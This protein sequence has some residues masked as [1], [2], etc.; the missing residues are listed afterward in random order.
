[1]DAT[2]SRNPAARDVVLPYSP[3][4]AFSEFH[5]RTQ[6]WAVLVC[7][8]RAGKTTAL[9][10][11]MLY[12]ALMGPGDGRYAYIAPLYS[13]AKAIAWDIL[14][15]LTEQVTVRKYES[16]LRIDL[17]N[18][19]R[20]RLFGS[21]NPDTLR[22][23]RF[24]GVAIDEVG[25][26]KPNLFDEVVRPAL[27]DRQGWAVFSGTPKGVGYFRDLYDGAKGDPTWFVSYLP[28]SATGILSPDELRDAAK[29]MSP[30]VYAQE[31]ECS[32]AAPRSGSYYGELL[33]AAEVEGRIGDFPYDPEMAVACAFDIGWR[34]ST[35]VWY[36]QPRPGGYAIIDHDEA[37]GRTVD[38]WAELLKAKG[39]RYDTVWLPHDARAKSFQTG[40]ST[41]EQLLAHHLPC[42]I[43]PELRVQQGIDA[44]RMALPKC[45]FHNPT[46]HQ[47]LRRLRQYGRTWN[48]RAQAFSNAPKHDENSHSADAF[49]M[50]ALVMRE[51]QGSPHHLELPPVRDVGSSFSLNALWIERDGRNPSGA[52]AIDPR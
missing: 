1:V 41:V 6:R 9:L 13:Q 7:H 42:R 15:G 37:A 16:E 36:W 24:D 19:A 40:R 44:V 28:A 18:G 17:L 39:Y 21:D 35:A 14:L 29:L 30:E 31:F 46:C 26:I 25:D 2:V 48:D 11:D 27:A 51:H 45:R 32:W 47:G 8:R 5:H 20:I 3:R 12:R 52:H 4:A 34:D 49:R 10:F 43:A 33:N 38:E 50:A 22:G 23:M